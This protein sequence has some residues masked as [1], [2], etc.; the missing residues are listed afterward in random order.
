MPGSGEAGADGD[1]LESPIRQEEEDMVQSGARSRVW[2]SPVI[3][4]TFSG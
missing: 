4:Q 1:N 3:I 2:Q